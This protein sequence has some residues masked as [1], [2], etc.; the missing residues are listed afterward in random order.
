[1]S[2][3]K[4]NAMP[5]IL[6]KRKL[7]RPAGQS[8]EKKKAPEK[9][10]QPAPSPTKKPEKTETPQ[11]GR[12]LRERRFA[13]GEFIFQENDEA[14]CG[15]V[16]ISGTVEICKITD[17]KYT[18][19][20]EVGEGGL[21][22]EMAVIDPA[23]RSAAARAV[24]DT[25]VREVDEDALSQYITQTP[26]MAVSIMKRLS[27][28]V[29]T[30]NKALEVSA[31]E[32]QPVKENKAEQVKETVFD[33][34]RKENI[35]N[36]F[37]IDE[38][39]S[40]SDTIARRRVP[41]VISYTFWAMACLVVA[42]VLWAS[43]SIIDIF[44]SANG[45]LATTVPKITVQSGEGA[46]VR[47]VHVQ[48][49]ELVKEGQVLATLDPT[50][51]E[52]DY[53]RQKQEFSQVLAQIERLEA[54]RDNLDISIAPQISDPIQ[55]DIFKNR[56][57]EYKSKVLTYD[58]G[59]E[60]SKFA[61]DT[62]RRKLEIARVALK[63][64]Q[65]TYDIN[66]E[67]V[68]KEVFSKKK[69]VEEAFKLDK[70]KIELRSSEI[71]L[72]VAQGDLDTAQSDR[73]AF[74][75]G[76]QKQINEEL[77]TATQKRA[78]LREELVKLDHKRGN[79]QI[80]APK[81]GIILELQDLFVG[82]IVTAGQPVLTLVPVDVPLNVEMDIDPQNISN[83]SIGNEVSVKLNALPFQKHGDLKAQITFISADTVTTS[84]N[85]EEGTY[86]RARA[87]I[88]HNNLRKVPEGFHLIPGMQLN[89]DIIVGKRRLITY[90]LYPVIRTIETSFREP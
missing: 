32:A 48:A 72:K 80:I 46:S 14:D 39:Q 79:I 43:F 68:D 9:K 66:K 26:D 58:L 69:M 45:R 64:A 81:S 70:A 59:V 38:F 60:K 12:D 13:P 56:W 20:T 83:L 34:L 17:G 50:L 33:K 24:G 53:T 5:S 76:W 44:M 87:E 52:A 2:E 51:T 57:Q 10:V 30:S 23:P 6:K 71:A 11:A 61:L 27:T 4:K 49:G 29:R 36:A 86:Y 82:S 28:Y 21:F 47:S 85:G 22:G 7:K 55:L 73:Q 1:M 78:S 63:E 37:I 41:P 62:A 31:F 89:A 74:I 25:V 84:I 42:C 19:L 65:H 88:K 67:L 15:Y 40:P 18:T 16:V 35:D 90:V 77:S 3:I 8:A 54:E 75:S